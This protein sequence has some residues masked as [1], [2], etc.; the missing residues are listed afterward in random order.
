MTA[1]GAAS[2]SSRID[3]PEAF[4]KRPAR[5]AMSKQF[6]AAPTGNAVGYELSSD[7][8]I[9]AHMCTSSAVMSLVAVGPA[10]FEQHQL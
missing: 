8:V 1:H 5:L 4:E 3:Q 6:L 9:T 10:S 7:E 2:A